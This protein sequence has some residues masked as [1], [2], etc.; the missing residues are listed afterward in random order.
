[1]TGEK[2]CLW[3]GVAF[4]PLNSKAKYC[5]TAHR[6][7]AFKQ[8]K[9]WKRKKERLLARQQKLEKLLALPEPQTIAD[10]VLREEFEFRKR[11]AE[12]QIR[13]QKGAVS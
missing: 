10:L 6:V 3:C 1:M 7:A 12:E 13:R 4:A 9:R 11:W 5:K 2:H 8:R